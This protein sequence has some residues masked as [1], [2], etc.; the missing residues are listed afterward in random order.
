MRLYSLIC[1]LSWGA[2]VSHMPR[3]ALWPTDFDRSCP[4]PL[5]SQAT[6]GFGTS[7]HPKLGHTLTSL[8]AQSSLGHCLWS[9]GC[10]C[11]SQN[12]WRL[13][14]KGA[15]PTRVEKTRELQRE[16]SSFQALVL[17]QWHKKAGAAAQGGWSA[18]GTERYKINKIQ[19]YNAWGEFTGGAHEAKTVNGQ[20]G[21][22]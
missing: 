4:T 20:C 7:E 13:G 9:S 6:W 8:R 18:G 11:C 12:S 15:Q 14:G 1:P 5:R 10:S 17:G 21:Q 2:P 19:H 3:D 16:G 22:K